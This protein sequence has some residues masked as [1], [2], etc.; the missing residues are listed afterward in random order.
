MRKKKSISMKLPV[1]YVRWKLNLRL[2]KAH[3][4]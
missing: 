3:M 2:Q 4:R 1:I